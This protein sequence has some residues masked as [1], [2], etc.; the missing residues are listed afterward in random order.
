MVPLNHFR[1]RLIK[2]KPLRLPAF[3]A[4]KLFSL[5]LLGTLTHAEVIHL[6]DPASLTQKQGLSAQAAYFVANDATSIYEFLHKWSN[7]YHPREGTNVALQDMRI[8]LGKTYGE[9]LYFGYFYR[10][11]IFIAGNKDFTDL[12][13]KAKNKIDLDPD[14]TFVL[15]LKARGIKQSGFMIAGRKFLLERGPHRIIG[16]MSVSVSVGLDM[17]KGDIGGVATVPDPRTYQVSSEARYYYTHNYLYDLDVPQAHGLGYGF[18]AG[19][20]YY[21]SFYRFGISLVLNDLLSRM[22]WK[23]LPYSYVSIHTEN[24]S[25]DKNGYV[26][27][28]PVISGL[29]TLR[30]YTQHIATKYRMQMEF[31]IGEK[32]RLSCGLSHAYGVSFPYM[33]F[34]Y[35]VS[36]G[37]K[38]ACSY[39]ARF[40]S[41]GL[42]YRYGDFYIGL[43]ADRLSNASALGIRGGYRHRF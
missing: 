32:S 34:S 26:K 5:L 20:H 13:Q 4:G 39:E 22:H 3:P 15:K 37:Q 38:F 8:D 36:S 41:V 33:Q 27:Y 12:Y 14:R 17:Q 1:N 31:D 24:K 10:Y 43:D 23:D 29:E 40:G 7:H 35:E 11:N 6:F 16:G 42:D 9:N 28:T 18:D 19:V 30:D 25:Y 21:N 2:I